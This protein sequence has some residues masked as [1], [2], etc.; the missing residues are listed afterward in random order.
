M[1]TTDLLDAVIPGLNGTFGPGKSVLLNCYYDDPSPPSMASSQGGIGGAFNGSCNVLVKNNGK[2]Y[3]ALIISALA[4]VT[5]NLQP[6]SNSDLA[7]SM[8]VNSVSNL[9]V[10]NSAIGDV[11]A[12][13]IQNNIN[14]LLLGNGPFITSIHLPLSQFVQINNP[15]ISNQQGY[16]EVL[17]DVVPSPLPQ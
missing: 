4:N 5:S 10:K 14:N 2:W 1:L 6:T 11:S 16:V 3:S 9:Q 12:N 8:N 17:A 13:T 7:Y 15:I